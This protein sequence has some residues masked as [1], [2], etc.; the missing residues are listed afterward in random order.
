MLQLVAV[1]ASIASPAVGRR[2][3]AS[4]WKYAVQEGIVL[5]S[6]CI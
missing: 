6:P 5:I 4:N 2:T 1:A 3:V